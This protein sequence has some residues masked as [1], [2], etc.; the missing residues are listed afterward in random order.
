MHYIPA[1]NAR[2]ALGLVTGT[3]VNEVKSG[4][5]ISD[6]FLNTL[7]DEYNNF[8][9]DLNVSFLIFIYDSSGKKI[10]APTG[11][12]LIVFSEEDY[13]KKLIAFDKRIVKSKKPG[14][15]V[16]KEGLIE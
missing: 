4:V 9:K 16:L 5:F 11:M 8:I 7:V 15:I 3:S 2:A 6:I 1:V 14:I 12:P 13:E 10:K